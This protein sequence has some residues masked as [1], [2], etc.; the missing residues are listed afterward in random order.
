MNKN[1]NVVIAVFAD[2]PAAEQAVANLREWD[3]RVDEVKLGTIG[4][5][6]MA[7]GRLETKI[8]HSGIFKRSLPIS[9]NAVTALANEISGGEVAV[10][11][12]VDDYEVQMV[13]DSFNRDG[14]RLL[15]NQYDRT[16]EE[17]LKEQ[18][19]AEEAQIENSVRSL[20]EKNSQPSSFNVNKA[21]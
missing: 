17:I 2:A 19:D 10:A 14:G 8:V 5:I 6:T 9:E 7:A 20:S 1:E 3:K 12:T 21:M 18:K 13:S 11:V 15:V 4:M 16:P